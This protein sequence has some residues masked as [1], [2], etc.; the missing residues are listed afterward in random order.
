MKPETGKSENSKPLKLRK[1]KK[2]IRVRVS[3]TLTGVK[4]LRESQSTIKEGIGN[5]EALKL[6]VARQSDQAS[7]IKFLLDYTE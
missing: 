1:G 4:G 2:R 3:R 7:G 5:Y 6:M